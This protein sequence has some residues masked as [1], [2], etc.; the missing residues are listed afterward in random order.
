MIVTTR[1]SR[2][3]GALAGVLAVACGGEAA[4]PDRDLAP[5]EVLTLATPVSAVQ[6]EASAELVGTFVVG[7]E[8]PEWNVRAD[9][10]ELGEVETADGA[11]PVLRVLSSKGMRV[12]LPGPFAWDAVD[13]VEVEM[14]ARGSE[15]LF[16]AL[17]RKGELVRRSRSTRLNGRGELVRLRFDLPPTSVDRE[18]SDS[19]SLVLAG[20]SGGF[21]LRSVRL[22]RRPPAALLGDPAAGPRHVIVGGDESR[23]A[24]VLLAGVGVSTA[25]SERPVVA[26]DR[27]VVQASLSEAAR[28]VECAPVLS[29]RVEAED[30]RRVEGELELEA[31]L[32]EAARWREWDLDLSE[33]EGARVTATF[34]FGPEDAVG[35]LLVDPAIRR[36]DPEARTVVLVTSDTHRADHLGAHPASVEVSTPFLDGLAAR[37]TYFVDAWTPTNTTNP[38]HGAVM[39]AVHPRDTGILDNHTPLSADAPTLAE[40]FRAAGF[41]TFAVVSVPHLVPE[42]SGFG[43]G[44]ERFSGPR[45]YQ[46]DSEETVR[47]AKEWIDD[48]GS[49]PLFLWVHVFDA[50]TP[51][52]PPED[53]IAE[54]WPEDR[55]PKDASLPE[56]PVYA[57]PRWAPE[58]RDLEYLEALYRAEVS[59]VDR[60]LDRLLFVPRLSEGVV[61]VT[62]DHGE[63][64]GNHEIF[65]DHRELYPDTLAV[66]LVL[67]GPGVPRGVT[68]RRPVRTMDVGRTL[69]DLAGLQ[70]A[71]FP[72]QS[73]V[74]AVAEGDPL[75]R[76]AISADRTSASI[77][78]G[79]WFLAVHLRKH[80]VHR[81]APL[82]TRHE[83]ELYNLE[84]DPECGD[85]RSGRDHR[86]A[87]RL[88]ERLVTWLGEA[89]QDRWAVKEDLRDADALRQLAAMGYSTD[90]AREA[91]PYFDPD[92][93]C[94]NCARFR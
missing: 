19:V 92:C 8:L 73:L 24:R 22:F 26:G 67:A 89:R 12:D 91:G 16:V 10:V 94:E 38:S 9:R 93:E 47:I 4:P 49:D 20:R 6:A 83:T 77:Q 45:S 32:S 23:P 11:V 59:Y 18:D 7:D 78:L 90:D 39:T 55:D 3:A 44:F 27:L 15:D 14:G 37:G 75:P 65:W 79:P 46:R 66:P 41:R 2:L 48:V 72:G 85:E 51:Y 29:V 70:D 5:G 1:A 76:Y 60:A 25:R 43:Q 80:R 35:C 31:S 63:S 64:L 68:S 74:E 42:R 54:H 84:E 88:R 13:R 34:T 71:E 62:A 52:E 87:A 50:H 36:R 40:A 82:V 28:P 30:G 17:R 33:L 53:L 61:L 81:L 69:L 57:R 56:P 58:V 86:V 21:L